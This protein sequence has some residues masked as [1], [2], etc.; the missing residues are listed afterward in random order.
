LERN[1]VISKFYT[2]NVTCNKKFIGKTVQVLLPLKIEDIVNE[3]IFSFT[4][5]DVEVKKVEVEKARK[6]NR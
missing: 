6:V 2:G 1:T 5:E 4:I 3:Y